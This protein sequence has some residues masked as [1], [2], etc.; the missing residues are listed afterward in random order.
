MGIDLQSFTALGDG[1]GVDS[2]G[3]CANRQSAD[4]EALDFDNF[5][6]FTTNPMDL[7]SVS[8][9]ERMAYPPSNW[10]LTASSC[11]VVEYE[12]TF[13]WTELTACADADG[14]ALVS[15]TETDDSVLLEGTFF[16]ELVSP[17]SMSSDEYYRS[18]PLIQQDFGV[19]LSR[20]VNV[21]S[22]AN[23]QLFIASVMGYGRHDDDGSYEVTVLIQSADY[24]QLLME[25]SV[26]ISSISAPDG[27]TVSGIEVENSECLVASS[28]TCGQI[29]KV[30]VTAE[31][32]GPEPQRVDL[33]G[34]YQFA[35]TPDCQTLD[36]GTTDP[37]CETFLGTLDDTDGKVVLDVDVSYVDYCDVSLFEVAFG[38]EMAFYSDAVFAEEVDGES[39]PFVIGQDT[40]YGKVVVDIPD[41]SGESFAFIDVDGPYKVIGTGFDSKYQGNTTYVVAANNEAVFSFL[42]SDTPRETINVH[43]QLLVTMQT[44]SGERRRMRMLLQSG[45]GAES[46]A[47]KSYIGTASVQDADTTTAPLET[48]GAAAF[49]A[50][51]DCGDRLADDGMI[52]NVFAFLGKESSVEIAG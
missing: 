25:D 18:F 15:V 45:D 20:T 47:F 26:S 49:Y 7:E 39:D 50:G 46:N 41:E 32:S 35:F 5:F 29:F 12:K 52:S 3:T 1:H 48:D 34:N 36:D 8:T 37:A 51:N 38:A 43:V 22:S 14:N 31:C 40:I 27:V 11:N 13:S 28:F 16:V 17:Y 21:L 44:E 42:T 19:A 9:S 10:T 4:Y 24:A 2:A 6:G 33:S 30:A 23:T